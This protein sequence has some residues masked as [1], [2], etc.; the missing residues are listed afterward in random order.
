MQKYVNI[1]LVAGVLSGI[2]LQTVFRKG[3]AIFTGKTPTTFSLFYCKKG[4]NNYYEKEFIA[5]AL[6]QKLYLLFGEHAWIDYLFFFCLYYSILT[7]I[8]PLCSTLGVRK[9]SPKRLHLG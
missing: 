1:N 5:D 4:L 3:F 6:L 7:I 2:F 9:I 8:C